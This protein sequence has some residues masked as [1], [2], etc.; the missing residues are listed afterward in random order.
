MSRTPSLLRLAALSAAAI[1]LVACDSEGSD[2]PSG[3]AETR[4]IQDLPGDALFVVERGGPAP[5]DGEPSAFLAL[6]DF[7]PLYATQVPGDRVLEWAEVRRSPFARDGSD[8]QATL[9]LTYGGDGDANI[10]WIAVTQVMQPM[11]GI[12]GAPTEPVE[13]N[14]A[15]GLLIDLPNTE[16]IQLVWHDCGITVTL[17]S[18]V[19]DRGELIAMGESMTAECSALAQGGT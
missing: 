11:P 16:A 10:D 5:F 15:E 3:E 12:S 7:E 6:I 18:H 2:S 4:R 9:S 14:G 1:A 17:M 19:A 8:P 13:V